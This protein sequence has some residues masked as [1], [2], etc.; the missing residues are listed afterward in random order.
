[1]SNA[2]T[3]PVVSEQHCLY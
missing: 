3:C 1:M 2:N